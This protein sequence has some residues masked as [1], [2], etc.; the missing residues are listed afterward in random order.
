VKCHLKNLVELIALKSP[1]PVKLNIEYADRMRYPGKDDLRKRTCLYRQKYFQ[2]R[3]DVIIGV[4]DE[5]ADIQGNVH[6][7]ET[8]LPDTRRLISFRLS[9]FYVIS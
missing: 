2:P 3:M 5:T 7:I 4:G 9:S 8:L 1:C 6:L